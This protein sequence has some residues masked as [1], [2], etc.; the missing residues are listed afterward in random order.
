M[1]AAFNYTH[2]TRQAMTFL[3]FDFITAIIKDSG[4]TDDLRLL[5]F[6]RV[7]LY[8]RFPPPSSCTSPDHASSAAN[9]L[10]TAAADGS[11]S[12]STTSTS[13]TTGGSGG[14]APLLIK[15][16]TSAM[17]LPW[18]GTASL[19][20]SPQQHIG[21]Q[22]LSLKRPTLS[23]NRSTVPPATASAALAIYSDLCLQLERTQQTF[24]ARAVGLLSVSCAY[25]LA[26]VLGAT[27][28]AKINVSAHT[29]E[30]AVVLLIRYFRATWAS[31]MRQDEGQVK[32]L[33]RLRLGNARLPN[34]KGLLALVLLTVG[35]GCSV[36]FGP[37]TL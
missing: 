7:W 16:G 3:A 19:S 18:H 33:R 25:L 13:T 35:Y 29:H 9:V 34:E 17:S 28:S 20:R 27:N 11:N 2:D 23:L 5:I 21:T 14:G 32:R 26:H 30:I 37:W 4:F 36:A 24:I 8:S 1:M 6:Q 10:V 22:F 31:S 15:G 12:S